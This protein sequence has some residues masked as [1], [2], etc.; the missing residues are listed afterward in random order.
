[1][2]WLTLPFHT[3]VKYQKSYVVKLH[4]TVVD[5][6]RRVCK[7]NEYMQVT[8]L[9]TNA[10]EAVGY[11][12]VFNKKPLL[13][14]SNELLFATFHKPTDMKLDVLFNDSSFRI[15]VCGGC[16]FLCAIRKKS[17]DDLDC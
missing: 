1:M 10:K 11:E 2:N 5:I 4:N 8:Q 12:I 16:E 3:W 14:V 9:Y 13:W 17:E 15:L 6:Q 7:T